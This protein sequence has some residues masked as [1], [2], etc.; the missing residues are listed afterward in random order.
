MWWRNTSLTFSHMYK[1]AMLNC[2][3]VHLAGLA[4]DTAKATALKDTLDWAELLW[5]FPGRDASESFPTTVGPASKAELLPPWGQWG[6][7]CCGIVHE[8]RLE[9]SSLAGGIQQSL[10]AFVDSSEENVVE[11]ADWESLGWYFALKWRVAMVSTWDKCWLS[12]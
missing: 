2:C 10:L 8:L 4:G 12:N 9:V 1:V 5:S 6:T 11:L 7:V 3:R